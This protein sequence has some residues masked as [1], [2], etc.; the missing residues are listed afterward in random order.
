MCPNCSADESQIE[1]TL[2]PITG[3]E[4]Y[5]CWNCGMWWTTETEKGG[6]D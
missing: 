1:V 4:E 2:N 6:G 5:H 3:K